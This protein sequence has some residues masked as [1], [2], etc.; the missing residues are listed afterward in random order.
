MIGLQIRQDGQIFFNG[1]HI[2]FTEDE[3]VFIIKDDRSRPIGKFD[4]RSE[5][6]TII[7]EWIKG[8]R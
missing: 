2:G 8:L 3:T 5:I 7:D 1:K 4:H 6:T